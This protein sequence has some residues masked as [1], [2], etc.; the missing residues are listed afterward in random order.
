MVLLSVAVGIL[1]VVRSR[2]RTA[3]EQN[4]VIVR[5]FRDDKADFRAD[6]DRRLYGFTDE[7]HRT[8]LGKWI[9]VATMEPYNYREELR[10]KI[11]LVR[12]Q[13]V[14]LDAD[15]NTKVV[16]GLGD[17]NQ[18]KSACGTTRNCPAFIPSWV[19]GDELD[20]TKQVFESITKQ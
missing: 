14:I 10:G 20:A 4:I 7:R 17:L 15:E 13:L 9:Y 12:P 2:R 5:V 11:A 1:L 18:A 3:D 6:L 8:S 16:S 19:S